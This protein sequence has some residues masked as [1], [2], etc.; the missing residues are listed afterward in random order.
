[1]IEKLKNNS[2][3]LT[4]TI[5][6]YNEEVKELSKTIDSFLNIPISKRLFIVDNSPSDVLKNKFNHSDIDYIFV[7][8]NIGFGAGHN[9]II[10]QIK[11]LSTYHLILNPD[12]SFKPSTVPNLIEIIEKNEDLALISPKVLFPNGTHQYT[13]RRYPTFPELII[14]S[15]TFLKYIFPSIIKKGEYGDKDLSQ[16]FYPDFLHGCFQLY[17]TDCFVQL[18]GFDERYFLYM[19]D[20][21]ICRRIDALGKKKLYYP[22]EEIVHILKKDSSKNLKLFLIHLKSSIKYFKKWN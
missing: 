4:A 2:T 6:L 21:D 17:K 5:V 16:P 19:E 13:S 1:M 10:N 11:K 20:V 3:V 9:R 8:N 15:I 22:K 14:R 7:G 12:V 18:K